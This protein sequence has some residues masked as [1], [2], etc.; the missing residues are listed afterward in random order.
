[1][2]IYS[3][4]LR[5]TSSVAGGATPEAAVNIT[6]V[7]SDLLGIARAEREYAA[8]QGHYA[9]L[10]DLVSAKYVTING[11]RPPYS[12]QVE[13]SSD[14]FRVTATRS[15]PGSPSQIWIDDRMEIHT[16]Q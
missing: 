3:S 4:Q 8:E 5:S 16:S 12:Y 14:G 1:M 10:D 6:G 11:G 13:T 9:S 7:Q 15:T 2:Y